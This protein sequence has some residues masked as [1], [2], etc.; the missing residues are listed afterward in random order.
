[1]RR[2]PAPRRRLIIFAAPAIRPTRVVWRVRCRC[3]RQAADAC[4]SCASCVAKGAK[5]PCVHGERRGA[6]RDA[7]AFAM[8]HVLPLFAGYASGGKGARAAAMLLH[9]SPLPLLFRVPSSS[10]FF[11]LR[12]LV[13][14][15]T[16]PTYTAYA[17]WRQRHALRRRQASTPMRQ[18]VLYDG[19]PLLRRF[20]SLFSHIILRSFDSI[21]LLPRCF[22]CRVLL[23]CFQICLIQ[24]VCCRFI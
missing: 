22:S 19:M 9:I 10:F 8:C 7:A 16:L 14:S 17:A 20:A 6:E 5:A 15:L 24:D 11:F 2:S 3:Q 13:C 12:R 23:Y 1:M 21:A 4:A 18:R